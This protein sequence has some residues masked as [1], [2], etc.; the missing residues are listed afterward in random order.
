MI[1]VNEH[2][3]GRVV[4]SGSEPVN[5][6]CSLIGRGR[7]LQQEDYRK[8]GVSTYVEL[9]FPERSG[10]EALRVVHKCSCR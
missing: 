9:V 4:Q 5:V 1:L 2:L 7:C 6:I 8:V 3:L 10:L